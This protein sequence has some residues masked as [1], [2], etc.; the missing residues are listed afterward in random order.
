MPSSAY[1]GVRW[2]S[3]KRAKGRVYPFCAQGTAWNDAL[4]GCL[5]WTEANPAMVRAN[6]KFALLDNENLE[7]NSS[8]GDEDLSGP[9]VRP[10]FFLLCGLSERMSWEYA[11]HR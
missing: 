8:S 7:R 4:P 6:R 5:R 10:A 1:R 3:S 9:V 11:L 2:G